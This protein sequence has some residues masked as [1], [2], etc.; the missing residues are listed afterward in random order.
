M[1]QKRIDNN[2]Q[3]NS[4]RDSGNKTVKSSLIGL[5]IAVAISVP[6]WGGDNMMRILLLIFLYISLGQMWNL[7]AGYAGLV[8]LGQQIFIGLGGYA[9]AVVTELYDLPIWL[10]FLLAGVVSVIF[11]LIISVPIFKMSGV[12]FTIGTWIVAEALALFFTNWAYVRYGQGFNLTVTYNMTMTMIYL[13]AAVIGIGSVALVFLIMRSKLGLALMAMR[14]N[15]SAAETMGVELYR[16]KLKCFLISAFVTGIT[17]AG[18]YL[19]IAFI[20]P[21]AAFGISWT[22]SMVF[23]VIIGGIGTMEGPVI[24][25]IL[26]VLINQYLYNFPG[27]SMVILGVLAIIIIL[28]APNGVMGTLHNKTGFEILSPRRKLRLSR[29]K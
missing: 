27:F 1:F 9:L 22:V 24:G 13:I 20:Q 3:G 8:S 6:F 5:L 28:G 16:T 17:G 21:P 12:Y 4:L 11:A 29:A 18:I 15:E 10:G 25:A 26:Y 14:D 7:L 2:I 23:I 19:N